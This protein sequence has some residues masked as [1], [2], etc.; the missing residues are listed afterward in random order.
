MSDEW[1]E[2]DNLLGRGYWE[3]SMKQNSCKIVSKREEK[4]LTDRDEWSTYRNFDAIYLHCYN[5]VISAGVAKK[6]DKPA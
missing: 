5:K 4:L 6:L 2:C 3:G 1:S